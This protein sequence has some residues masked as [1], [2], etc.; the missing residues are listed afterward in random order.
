MNYTPA[1]KAAMA[2]CCVAA[3]V[4]IV[5]QPA[6]ATCKD[7]M[8]FRRDKQMHFV[9]S[10]VISGVVAHA[11]DSKAAG[12]VTS[13]VVGAAIEISDSKR[14]KCGSWQDFAF[15]LL[16]NLAGLGTHHIFVGPNRIVFRKEF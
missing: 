11:T 2:L 6:N 16:G 13:A 14:D 1:W 4:A 8:Q 7:D 15:D 10:G 5:C 9:G 3:V 12:F